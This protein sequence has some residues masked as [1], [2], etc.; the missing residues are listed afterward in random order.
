MIH[1]YGNITDAA[2]CAMHNLLSTVE[3]LYKTNKVAG[4]R[5]GALSPK[6]KNVVI[7]LSLILCVC[8]IELVCVI[9][10]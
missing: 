10:T 3:T 7:I 8:V 4:Y 1:R 5:Q 9:S 2:Q 6:M